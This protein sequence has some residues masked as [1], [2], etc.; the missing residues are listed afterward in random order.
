MPTENVSEVN[1]CAMTIVNEDGVSLLKNYLPVVINGKEVFAL[2]DSGA[3]ICVARSDVLDNVVKDNYVELPLDRTKVLTADMKSL[4]VIRKIRVRMCLNN[5]IVHADFYLV[6]SL[7]TDFILGLDWLQKHNVRID[8]R[9]NRLSID[10]RRILLTDNDV[11]V[12]ANSEAV[13]IARI[14]GDSLPTGV[15]GLTDYCTQSVSTGLLAGKTMTKI[16]DDSVYH[17]VANVTDKDVTVK[18]GTRIGKFVALSGQ[19]R[20]VDITDTDNRPR[21]ANDKSTE[22]QTTLVYKPSDD[23]NIDVEGLTMSQKEQLVDTI[24]DL[25]DTFVGP[26]GVLGFC[27]VIEHEIELEPNTRP[28]CQRTYRLPP[29]QRNVMQQEINNML[30]QGVIEE[31]TSPWG[32]TVFSC[33]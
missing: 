32:V 21:P 23:V 33:S 5:D 6:K 14:K 8:F 10:P 11:I 29:K 27:D 18:K 2:V 30:K 24:N 25:A 16:R 1:T 4:E 13:V 9:N 22:G 7:Q 31:S 3:D 15:V 19:D 26:D 28:S 17:I 20:L 12:P